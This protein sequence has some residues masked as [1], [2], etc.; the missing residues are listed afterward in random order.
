MLDS[1]SR[2][3]QEVNSAAS[4]DDALRLIV[5]RVKLALGCDVCSVY[6]ADP[7]TDDY[8][9]MA[10]DGLRRSAV[11]KV[12]LTA[13]RGLIGL[14]AS[15]AEPVNLQD[16]QEHA[17][18]YF[19]ASVGEAPF[20]GF[21]GV[22]IV[23]RRKILGVL[24][25]QQR[26]ARRFTGD[27]ESFLATL[28]AQLAASISQAEIRES[29][30]RLDSNTLAGTLFL[31]GVA[32]ARGIGIGEAV[33]LFPDAQLEAVPDK[34]LDDPQLEVAR[35]RQAVA[36]EMA[37]LKRLGERMGRMLSP[38]DR[39][40]FDAYALLLSSDSLIN[41]TVT[42]IEAGHWAPA[43]LRTTVL[44]YANAFEEMEDPY[45]QGRA[46]DIRDLGQRLLKRLLQVDDDQP[47]AYPSRTVL[48][49]V[50]ITVSQFL[51]VDPDKLA[52]VVS[53]RGTGA[54]HLALLA[55]GMGIP[56]VFG[57]NDAPLERLHGRE[58]VVDG[59]SA[60]VCIRPGLAL[61]QEYQRLAAEDAELSR[62]LQ[63]LKDL[64]AETPDGHRVAL[65]TNS[66]LAA[67]IAA[68][69][70]SGAEGVGLYRSELHF[71]LRD[72][73]PSEDD[74]TE[75]YRRVLKAMDPRPVVLRTLDVGGD[76]PLS[77]FP[78]D[79]QNPF[80]GWRGIRVSLDQPD[81]FKTQLRAMLKAGAELANLAIMFPMI[82]SLGELD[83]ALATLGQA[84]DELREDGLTVPY[85]KVGIMV[86]VPS[87]AYLIE[88]FAPRVDFISVGSNDLTQYLLAVDRNNAR[89]AKLYDG[90]H[91]A[92]LQ[93]IYHV[94][95]GAH[96]AGRPVGVCGE[97]AGD[98]VAALLLTAMGVDSLSMSLGNLLK[99]K[100]AVRTVPLARTKELLAE[101]L[102]AC[103]APPVRAKLSAVLDEYGL[104]GLIRAG[105]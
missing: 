36:V 74:Q 83:E 57:L 93:A 15:R 25:A 89:V 19:V 34:I 71:F 1:L 52:G 5:E 90:L 60:R 53:I 85:P 28:A 35:F 99:V 94:V 82:A 46:A 12:R 76:K 68:A 100:W 95:K 88:H 73:F 80:L 13:S 3:V 58:V 11:G 29:L 8:V 16:A 4:L 98:P 54:S 26:R 63:D 87:T 65:H 61:R 45:L 9:L 21:L 51:E 105:K 24:V 6:L 14:V 10:T 2:I 50:E 23:R 49:G 75:I 62:H 67:D 72:R 79:E 92:V 32:S 56:A 102:A 18:F 66:G 17:Q 84:H 27:E 44:E 7:E 59:Y 91:P 103:D 42:R 69:R 81:I 33:V 70:D 41:G 86:E 64:P 43:A 101:A 78:I 22:P 31:D 30:D 38:G 40:L 77:Y 97:M 20:H 96:A 104:G 48:M 37:E 39:A 47:R 55:R